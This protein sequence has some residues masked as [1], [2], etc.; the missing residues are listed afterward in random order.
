M[1]THT[2]EP[3][4]ALPSYD[5]KDLVVFLPED[6][7]SEIVCEVVG[8]KN[9]STELLYRLKD[10]ISGEDYLASFRCLQPHIKD[11]FADGCLLSLDPESLDIGGFDADIHEMVSLLDGC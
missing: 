5:V 9:T 7:Q 3:A 10:R 11:E 2:I 6:T 1:N 8:H 4:G